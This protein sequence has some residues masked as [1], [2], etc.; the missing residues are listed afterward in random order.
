VTWQQGRASFAGVAQSPF[1]LAWH[2]TAP[3]L[4]EK[5]G[6]VDKAH[7]KYIN[8]RDAWIKRH[9]RVTSRPHPSSQPQCQL[10][11]V[12]HGEQ[13]RDGLAGGRHDLLQNPV[14]HHIPLLHHFPQGRRHQAHRRGQELE[15]SKGK[16]DICA[17]D[18]EEQETTVSHSN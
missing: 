12:S 11:L 3:R 1:R 10:A 6:T 18:K 8:G 13:P 5:E 17:G 14:L 2:C 16:A 9:N 15:G 4:T 7:I